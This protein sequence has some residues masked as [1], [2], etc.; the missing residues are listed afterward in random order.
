MYLKKKRFLF[1]SIFIV[2]LLLIC[3]S[4]LSAKTKW[5][6]VTNT[7]NSFTDSTHYKLTRDAIKLIDK[8]AYKD[9]A[10]KFAG[11]IKD[12]TSGSTDDANAHDM[13]AAANGCIDI[14]SN[15]KVAYF[16]YKNLQL[17]GN[18]SAYYY[19]ALIAHLIEDMA[20]PPHA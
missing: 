11:D 15:W 12:C 19:I 1:E 17:K 3:F 16:Q 7:L 4:S 18:W 13:N 5:F 10:D 9:V 20:A 14:N 2:T 6:S 8:Y